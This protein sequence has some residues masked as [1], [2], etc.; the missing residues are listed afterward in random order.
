MS[1]KQR[2]EKEKGG[3]TEFKGGAGA[4]EGHR[5]S[6]LPLKRGCPASCGLALPRALKPSS[7]SGSEDPS[8]S[9]LLVGAEAGV[10]AP[11]PG[12]RAG[13]GRY[14]AYGRDRMSEGFLQHLTREPGN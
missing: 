13:T 3:G 6:S 5:K 2:Q 4:H 1:K 7:D 9:F 8:I 10:C 14:V 12:H 11:H